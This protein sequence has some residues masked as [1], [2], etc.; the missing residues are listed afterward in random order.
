MRSVN[1]V[2]LIWNL[3]KDP[4][5]KTTWSWHSFCLFTIA[6]NRD[7]TSAEWEKQSTT[8]FHKVAAWG[9]LANLCWDFLVKW[10]LVYIE[11]YLKTRTWEFEEKKYS[12]TEIVA[13]DMIMLNKK[14]EAEW[15]SEKSIESSEPAIQETN[16]PSIDM[17]DINWDNI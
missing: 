17:V 2:I 10:K 4:E 16:L 7:W 6:T 8:E 3:T 11:W 9:K 15:A 1:K 5:L 14:W 13:Q 12:K